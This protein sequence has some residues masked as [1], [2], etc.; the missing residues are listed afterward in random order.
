[1]KIIDKILGA[2]LFK[3]SLRFKVMIVFVLPMILVLSAFSYI[4]D[5]RERKE[6]E[7]QTQKSTVQLGDMALS[8]M[9]NAM[10][11]NDR[12]AISRILRNIGTNPAI[13]QMKIVNSGFLVTVSTDPAELGLTLQTSNTGCIECHGLSPANRP[14]VIDMKIGQDIMRV[15][16]PI[17]NE[18]ECQTCHPA[19]SNTHLGVL[20]IDAPLSDIEA[21]IAEEWRYNLSMSILSTLVIGTLAY[22]LIQWLIVKRVG[23]LYTYLNMFAAGDFSVRIPKLWRTEDEITRL[24]DH[25]NNI[26]DSLE[27]HE[28]EQREIVIVR[29]EVIAEEREKIAHELHDG[30]AQ[31]LAYLTTKIAAVQLLIH[32]HRVETA[33]D[34]LSQMDEAVRNQATDVR[35]MIAGLRILEQAGTDLT[36]SLEN[37]VTTCNRLSDLKISLETGPG[38]N[39]LHIEPETEIHLLRIVQESVSNARKHSAA[40]EVKIRVLRDGNVL[41][42]EIEDNGIGFDPWQ[43]TVSHSPHFG[44]RTMGERA[45]KIGA[46]FKVESVPQKGTRVFVRLPLQEN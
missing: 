37:Y 11:R 16:T 27:R 28:K 14:R 6:M 43:L 21:A 1:M 35:S 40:T 36:K 31:L 18:K 15:V 25:F 33:D 29:Q 19:T 42:M 23:V 26:A 34:H 7:E 17:S 8:G 13:K 30:V 41:S 3:A 20:I 32:Q 12:D 10:L 44:L 46:T 9:K 4:H 22:L 45:E 5:A 39:G 38:I 24:A 2:K